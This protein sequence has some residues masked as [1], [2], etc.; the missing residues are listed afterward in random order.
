MY[1]AFQLVADLIASQIAFEI[2]NPSEH[3]HIPLL[4]SPYSFTTYRGS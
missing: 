2:E 4:I 1:S 3:Y